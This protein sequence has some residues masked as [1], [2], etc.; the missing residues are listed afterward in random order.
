ML[1]FDVSQFSAIFAS[2]PMISLI[3]GKLLNLDFVGLFAWETLFAAVVILG[4][5]ITGTGRS[6]L[7]N[8][9]ITD[10][11][12]A[13]G[14]GFGEF[15]RDCLIKAMHAEGS[16]FLE[17]SSMYPEKHSCEV[18]IFED[19]KKLDKPLT[20]QQKR[21]Q[22]TYYLKAKERIERYSEGRIRVP[23]K[24]YVILRLPKK[25]IVEGEGKREIKCTLKINYDGTFTVNR[26]RAGATWHDHALLI[27]VGVML[28]TMKQI[29][30]HLQ[31]H[32]YE[33]FMKSGHLRGRR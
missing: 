27:T 29:E 6:G 4:A 21:I 17:I 33:G 32:H 1:S 13:E 26:A 7:K 8:S 28:D 20:D 22:G 3:I 25:I 24:I 19:G 12:S 5:Y 9:V 16:K 18:V 14:D 31:M 2:G 11:F 30:S 23:Q 10:D 15:E